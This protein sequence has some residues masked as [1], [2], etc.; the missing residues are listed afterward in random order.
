MVAMGWSSSENLI[1]ILEEGTIVVYDVHGHTI[2]TRVL[3]RVRNYVC[4]CTC[5][6]VWLSVL[7][8]I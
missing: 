3:A 5:T 4:A 8:S 6:Y 1:C 7:F 2:F